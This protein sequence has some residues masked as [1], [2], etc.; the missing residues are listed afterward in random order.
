MV[1]DPAEKLFAME[2]ITNGL[3]PDRWQNSRTPPTKVELQSTTIL[4][5]VIE[6]A[7]AK[8]RTGGPGDDRHDLKDED[9]VTRVWTGVVPVWQCLG[10]PKASGHNR[11]PSVPDYLEQWRKENNESG[12]NYS[13]DVAMTKKK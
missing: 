9:L 13:H 8:I 2:L 3:V 5:V 4:K 10:D 7:S 1:T 6:S 12:E 11:L